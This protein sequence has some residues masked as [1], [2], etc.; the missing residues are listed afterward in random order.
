MKSENRDTDEEAAEVTHIHE[1]SDW[2]IA[3]VAAAIAATFVAGAL[4]DAW[5]STTETHEREATKRVM[6]EKGLWKPEMEQAK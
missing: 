6:I 4:S 5:K 1:A 2:W 3:G